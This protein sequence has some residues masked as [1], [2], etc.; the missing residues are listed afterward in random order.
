M[1]AIR[2]E[3][4]ARWCGAG[5]RFQGVPAAERGEDPRGR[6]GEPVVAANGAPH[7]T[8]YFE[9]T[10]DDP[11][12]PVEF[13]AEFEFTTSAYYPKLDPA[14]VKPYEAEAS[15]SA[16]TRPSARRTS[17]SRRESARPWRK[18]SATRR[19]RCS[20]PADFPVDQ[21]EH[22]LLLGDGILDDSEPVGQGVRDAPGRL[23]R[24]GNPVHPRCAAAPACRHGGSQAGRR[25]RA[26][27]TCTTGPSSTWSRGGW[28]P[29]DPSYGLQNHPDRRSMSSTWGTW[30]RTA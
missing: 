9:R 15:S 6:P 1:T 23:R 21:R 17:C 26:A 25:N 20:R 5:C 22:P 11:A 10:I 16:R 14:K 4:G 12:R 27:T 18:S 7:R 24:A 29:V 3:E 28:L 19:I 30:I 2:R 8:L 13:T